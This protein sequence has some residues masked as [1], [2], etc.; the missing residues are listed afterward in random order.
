MAYTKSFHEKKL[1]RTWANT[2]QPR[3]L[4]FHTE[5]GWTIKGKVQEDYYEWVDFFTATHPKY[6]KIE[7]DFEDTVT[8]ETQEAFEHFYKHHPPTEWDKSEI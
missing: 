7:G 5:S 8:A 4:G 1:F 3:D 6:G 2:L